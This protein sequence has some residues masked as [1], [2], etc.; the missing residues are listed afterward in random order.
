MKERIVK[1][2]MELTEQIAG[3]EK[4]I[5]EEK[6]RL[7]ELNRVLNNEQLESKKRL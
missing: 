7:V 2:E 3:T 1:Q 6:K 4:K 5:Y